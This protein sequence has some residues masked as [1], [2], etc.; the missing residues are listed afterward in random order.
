MLS[1]YRGC[2]V[3][4]EVKDRQ[5]LCTKVIAIHNKSPWLHHRRVGSRHHATIIIIKGLLINYYYS[6]RIQIYIYIYLR[7]ITFRVLM[8]HR[9]Y[10]IIG[11]SSSSL[12]HRQVC[13]VTAISCNSIDNTR[14]RLAF[15]N[16][17]FV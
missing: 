9:L 17:G 4:R 6:N 13:D 1:T 2:R 11:R 5:L 3:W 7:V 14:P 15:E 10:R 12:S 8:K 16:H